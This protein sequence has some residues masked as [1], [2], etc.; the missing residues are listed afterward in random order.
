MSTNLYSHRPQPWTELAHS[1]ISEAGQHVDLSVYEFRPMTRC[2][3]WPADRLSAELVEQLNRRGYVYL[4]AHAAPRGHV[5]GVGRPLHQVYHG[6]RQPRIILEL[7]LRGVY[8]L[9]AR[10][11]PLG[12]A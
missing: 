6:L 8:Q 5:A 7:D 4:G 1:P 3:L 11:R 10:H 12:R 9:L 2:R